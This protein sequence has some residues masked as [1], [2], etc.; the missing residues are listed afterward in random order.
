MTELIRYSRLV[1]TGHLFAPRW[2]RRVRQLLRECEQ[3]E[4]RIRR[5]GQSR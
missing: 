5:A 3:L 4:G 2:E 1:L